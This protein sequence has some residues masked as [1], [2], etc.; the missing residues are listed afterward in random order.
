MTAA[1]ERRAFVPTD[2]LAEVLFVAFG[3]VDWSAPFS[4]GPYAVDPDID[5]D[6]RDLSV[7]VVAA[8]GPMR[9]R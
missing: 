5:P 4:R 3:T 7:G 9:H 1:V 6:L 2:R 8:M